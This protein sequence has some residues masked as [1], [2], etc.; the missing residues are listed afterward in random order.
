[1]V[2]ELPLILENLSFH[3]RRREE[4]ALRNIS[5]S[6]DPGQIYLI[7]GAS[8]CGKTTLARCINGLIPRSYK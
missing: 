2:S 6:I 4:F 1:M 3:Y 5:F 8:G 7:A